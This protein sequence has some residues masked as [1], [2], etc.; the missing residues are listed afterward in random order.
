VQKFNR[1]DRVRSIKWGKMTDGPYV[2]LEGTVVLTRPDSDYIR[3]KL[4]NDPVENAENCTF[5]P[6][7]LE[8]IK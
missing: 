7:E 4:D 8:P 3:V 1:G 2:G 5:F 6:S